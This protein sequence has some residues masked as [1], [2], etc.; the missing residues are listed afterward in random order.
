MKTENLIIIGSGPSGYTAALYASR[1]NL[2]PLVIEGYQSGGLL[3]LT[4][5]VENFPGFPKGI[6]GPELMGHFRAQAERFG[7]RFIQKNVTKVNFKTTPFEVYIEDEK[8]TAHCVIVSTGAA[9]KWI[10]IESEQRLLGKGVSSCATCDG[11][12]FK[13]ARLV[14]VGGGDSAM[15]EANFLTRFASH[16]TLVHRSENFRASKIMLERAQKNP[17]ISFLTN[18][19]VEEILGT[20]GVVGARLKNVVT[21]ETKE[22]PC[23]GFFVAIGHEPNTA[24]LENQLE[25]DQK[26]YIVMKKLPTT[27]TSVKGVFAAGDVQ[28]KIYRQA[29]T[30][31]AS[32]CQA[33]ID[34]EKYLETLHSH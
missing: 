27:A 22:I 28:D 14:V 31:A 16:V 23:E 19:T 17:K 18:Y 5:E 2:N 20:D 13:G 15:E 30:T 6:L 25:L 21:N 12:F 4:S 29:I 9:T 11:A 26:G 8:L 10:G 32:G 3:M 24:F 33:A 34:T 1:A 7:T